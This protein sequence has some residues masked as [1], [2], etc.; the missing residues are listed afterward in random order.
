MR[1]MAEARIAASPDRSAA[2]RLTGLAYT[3]AHEE[4]R[5]RGERDH[6]PELRFRRAMA[7]RG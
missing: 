5:A 1:A 4:M 2:G 7:S 6:G 3:L